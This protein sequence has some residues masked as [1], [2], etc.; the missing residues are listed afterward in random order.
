M[1]SVEKILQ[2][3]I[4]SKLS[5]LEVAKA[6]LVSSKVS[7]SQEIWK[8]VEKLTNLR[9]ELELQMQQQGPIL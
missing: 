4:S 9:F 5:E 6:D 2:T 1:A 3:L 8:L 7:G